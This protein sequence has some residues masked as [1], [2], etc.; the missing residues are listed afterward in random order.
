MGFELNE[1]E[2]LSLSP[3]LAFGGVDLVS[4]SRHRHQRRQS[5]C[6]RQGIDSGV[7]YDP[8]C[9]VCFSGFLSVG[10]VDSGVIPVWIVGVGR[11]LWV[12]GCVG[13]K[14]NNLFE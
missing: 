4:R 14:M 8:F 7:S 9:W 12:G 2:C 13:K 10:C 6:S 5:C 11:W 1:V 3:P